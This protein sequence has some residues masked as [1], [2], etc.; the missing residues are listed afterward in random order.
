M[1]K[2]NLNYA[3]ILSPF[4]TLTTQP[5]GFS[6]HIGILLKIYEV[7]AKQKKKVGNTIM[8]S[9]FHAQLQS[10]ITIEKGNLKGKKRLMIT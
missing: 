8:I 5:K 6:V 9:H 7:K 4:T 1:Y 2:F 3:H 10:R